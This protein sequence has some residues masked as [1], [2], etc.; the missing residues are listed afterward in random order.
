[1]AKINQLVEQYNQNNAHPVDTPMVTGIQL[2][3]LDKN[4]PTP[5]KITEWVEHTLY[6][7]LVSSLMYLSIATRPDIAYAARRLTSFLDCYRPE[8]WATTI[9]VLCYLK[10]T[11]TFMPYLSWDT[12]Y[13]YRHCKGIFHFPLL[14][15]ILHLDPFQTGLRQHS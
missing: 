8:H 2:H 15:I 4:L 13:C 5:P 14:L 6:H 7:S 1:M 3:R 9:H 12:T 11:V 10:G